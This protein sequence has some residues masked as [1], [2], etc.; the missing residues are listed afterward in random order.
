MN[1]GFYLERD[2]I[3]ERKTSHYTAR[4]NLTPKSGCT[5]YNIFTY[6]GLIS[7]FW[8][9]FYPVQKHL[10]SII[11]TLFWKGKSGRRELSTAGKNILVYAIWLWDD[12]LEF[13]MSNNWQHGTHDVRPAKFCVCKSIGND[14]LKEEIKQI[15]LN[16]WLHVPCLQYLHQT[17]DPLISSHFLVFFVMLFQA[18]ITV[19]FSCC[20]FWGVSPSSLGGEWHPQLVLVIELAV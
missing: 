10:V 2:W 18:C 14:S 4:L 5:I 12:R 9:Y 20:L 16:L 19:Y 8:E 6:E 7:C 15:I 1:S 13:Q 3:K 11:R 17:C